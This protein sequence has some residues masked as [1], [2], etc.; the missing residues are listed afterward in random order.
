M[1]SGWSS[2]DVRGGGLFCISPD[3]K[4][5]ITVATGTNQTGNVDGCPILRFKKGKTWEHVVNKE[6]PNMSGTTLWILFIF[7]HQDGVQ[8]ELSSIAKFSKGRIEALGKRIILPEILFNDVK[9]K[10]K[11]QVEVAEV[12]VKRKQKKA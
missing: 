8:L 2:Y 12:V 11:Q 4:H 7:P 1:D 6:L 9:I 5:A 10:D 3:K